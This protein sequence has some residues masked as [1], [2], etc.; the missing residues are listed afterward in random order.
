MSSLITF[1]PLEKE[2]WD[3]VSEIYQ[4]GITTENATFELRTPSWENWNSNHLKH[5]RIVATINQNIVGWAALSPVSSRAVYRG[6]A[7]VS[8]YISLAHT[9]Q[10]IG[11]TLLEKLVH[12]SEENGIWT[13]KAGIFPENI[14]SLVIHKKCG[15][16]EV[17]V[18]EKIGQLKGIWRDTVLLERRSSHL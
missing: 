3:S 18:H 12:D 13:L 6:V 2:D 10:H 9:G 1:R 17:G 8:V 15:F 14:A 5:S 11:S 16:R 7:E 4:E